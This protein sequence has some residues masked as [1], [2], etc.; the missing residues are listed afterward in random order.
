MKSYTS[1]AVDD[2]DEDHG[3]PSTPLPGFKKP[4]A[5]NNANASDVLLKPIKTSFQEKLAEKG[6]D[7]PDTAESA[8]DK[9]K[10]LKRQADA[11]FSKVML[12]T[13]AISLVWMSSLGV[14][15]FI[16]QSAIAS[17]PFSVV[18]FECMRGWDKMV[19]EKEGHTACTS[20]QMSQC[21]AAL[22]GAAADEVARSTAASDQV[23]QMLH[24][25]ETLKMRCTN[26]HVRIMDGLEMIGRRGVPLVW[27]NDS[28]TPR[29]VEA[30]RQLLGDASREKQEA[31]AVAQAYADQVMASQKSFTDRVEARAEYDSQYMYNSSK[32]FI[33][34]AGAAKDG[35]EDEIAKMQD[36]LDMLNMS[37]SFCTD[38]ACDIP[39]LQEMAALTDQIKK[40]NMAMMQQ[41]AQ[42]SEYAKA[43][44][45][46]ERWMKQNAAK[47][48][49]VMS[50][51]DPNFNL[52][53]FNLPGIPNINIP[54]PDM[55]LD[56]D[57]YTAEFAAWSAE[58]ARAQK[59]YLA[60]AM[61]GLPD[62]SGALDPITG[63][64]ILPGYDPPPLNIANA[65]A[66]MAQAAEDFLAKQASAIDNIVG[67]AANMMGI[68][69]NSS[70]SWIFNWS[71]SDMTD[72]SNFD[73]KVEGFHALEMDIM[74]LKISIDNI[75]TMAV[76]ADVVWRVYISTRLVIKY[77]FRS[78]EAIP[79]LDLRRATL[80]QGVMLTG[81]A[82]VFEL[83]CS[84]IARFN[85][86]RLC[87]SYIL[88]PYSAA[89][90]G[91]F[92]MLF[93][94][95]A[96]TQVYMFSFYAYVEGCIEPPRNGTWVCENLFSAAYNYA[97]G[98]GD[99]TLLAGLQVY[100]ERRSREC[101]TYLQPSAQH[102]TTAAQ[103]YDTDSKI[104]AL[105]AAGIALAK[106]CLDFDKTAA[107]DPE[108]VLSVAS[109][110]VS[111]AEA[112]AKAAAA[113]D[114][115]D[116]AMAAA[117]ALSRTPDDG[118]C[119]GDIC[120]GDPL[121][122]WGNMSSGGWPNASQAFADADLDS[123]KDSLAENGLDAGSLSG[124]ASGF[125]WGGRRRLIEGA[126]RAL[127][128]TT[129]AAAASELRKLLDTGTP[130]LQDVNATLPDGVFS[131]EELP[132]CEVTC[133][134]PNR[135]VLGLFSNRCGCHS[136]WLFHGFVLQILLAI[137]VYVSMQV[138]RTLLVEG[139]LRITW[140][141]LHVYAELEV[142][143]TADLDSLHKFPGCLSFNARQL[144]EHV[145]R[146]LREYERKAIGFFLACPLSF[147]P[148]SWLLWYVAQN[149]T[150]TQDFVT[151]RTTTSVF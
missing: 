127:G 24:R 110:A 132:P 72:S 121:A 131:C 37:L 9:K 94:L 133:A 104:Y 95:N 107:G 103:H 140:R 77:W 11:C 78:S 62:I 46:M 86:V 150:Y 151:A 93:V 73:W 26:S 34:A 67:G 71:M 87:M 97:A 7:S 134:G 129:A 130:C 76:W 105:D 48:Q 50:G 115:A 17:P 117:E 144:F 108:I 68:G 43:A 65:T 39:I 148:I 1:V 3:L 21:D 31:M 80:Q 141:R 109:Q 147:A 36:R 14:A 139:V 143:G 113:A 49:Q 126:T 2:A 20:V 102:Q 122:G 138:A 53:D 6:P 57:V 28:C 112:A 66:E 85:P 120:A 45:S 116:A 42:W 79:P 98:D 124:M 33:D 111:E 90:F 61:G 4:T 55:N 10:L 27:S 91:G 19:S 101:A 5:G 146:H 38:S 100:N 149:I 12:C 137:L 99:K 128:P 47:M 22:E 41:A 83:A 70:G 136:E 81:A 58:M 64:E 25:V 123:I 60:D 40:M 74:G 135:E 13:I 32:G 8:A 51:I 119:F 92:L 15:R 23:D 142:L 35:V 16:V 96:V 44:E 84:F 88:S 54:L 145:A 29:E 114:A 89:A 106:K 63:L 118:A 75:F 56:M 69:D 18:S 59:E 125:D 52:P 30:A 82:S